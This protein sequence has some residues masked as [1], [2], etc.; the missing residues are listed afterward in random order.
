MA[1]EINTKVSNVTILLVED[2]DGHAK[3]IEKNLYR[4]GM[5]NNLVRASDGSEAI[6]YLFGEKKKLLNTKEILVLLDL[7][8][9]VI[10]GLQVLEKM[11]AEET[12][13]HI[14][15]VVLTTT[16]D[17]EEMKRCYE[18]GCNVYITKPVNYSKFSEVIQKLGSLFSIITVPQP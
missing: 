5:A 13:K 1:K 15:V 18:L 16:D 3:L 17:Y 7:N 2:N 11:K 4:A 12:T 6:D 9:P 8:L 10:N 14:P